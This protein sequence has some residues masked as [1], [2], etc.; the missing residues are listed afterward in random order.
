MQ[1]LRPP[2]FSRNRDAAAL[3]GP[4]GPPYAG[5][6][7]AP[8]GAAPIHA[9]S[10][11]SPAPTQSPA[12]GE[13]LPTSPDG[14]TDVLRTPDGRP[15]PRLRDRDVLAVLGFASLLLAVSWSQLAGYQ[16]ADSVEYMERA[17]AI[18]RGV[19]VIDSSAVRS[20]G[21]TGILLPIFA[22]AEWFGLDDLRLLPYAARLVQMLVSLA[23]V[24][25][26]IRLGA[27]LG[28]RSMGLAAG[29]FLAAN[30]VFLRWGVSPLSDVAAALGV[31]LG[32][33]ALLDRGP[34]R[35]AFVAGLLLGAS[36]LMAFKVVLAIGALFIP[37]F[38]REFRD[39]KRY[40][41]ALLWESARW[42]SSSARWTGPTTGPSASA[43]ATTCWRTSPRRWVR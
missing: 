7:R 42:R 8:E 39:N 21:Y 24:L 22:L 33:S 2:R 38:L 16:L 5:R 28:G 19:E 17:Q 41:V 15:L 37:V 18:V 29:V 10:A 34:P 3:R 6:P 43:S 20:F 25:A 32:L 13:E 30:A 26:T 35:R 14:P 11:G 4:R 27:R 31:L 12:I 1:G 9:V 36:L 40:L 23:L